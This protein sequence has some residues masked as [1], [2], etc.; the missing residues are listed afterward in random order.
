ME[1]DYLTDS[2]EKILMKR[3]QQLAKQMDRNEFLRLHAFA[4][5]N[6]PWIKALYYEPEKGESKGK[7]YSVDSIVIVT[8]DTQPAPIYPTKEEI[9]LLSKITD[10]DINAILKM[11]SNLTEEQLMNVCNGKEIK[12]SIIATFDFK[13]IMACISCLAK[14]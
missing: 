9:K 7:K 5:E 14:M 12:T 10:Y 3:I 4:R 13:L 2:T 11:L 8:K 1:K 6:M